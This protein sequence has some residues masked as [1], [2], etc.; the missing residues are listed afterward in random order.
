MQAL[1]LSAAILLIVAIGVGITAVGPWQLPPLASNWGLIDTMI[2]ITLIVTG[3]AFV[4]VNGALAYFAFKYRGRPE[5]RAAFIPDHP[6]LEK[7]LIAITV[8]GIVVLLAPGLF[9]YSSYIRSP[10]EALSVEVLGEQWRWLF[11]YAGPDGEL[12]RAAPEFLSA[13]N[14][15]GLDPT[16]PKGQDDVIALDALRLPKGRP[17]RVQIRAKDVLHSFYVPHF[18]V[19]MDAVPGLVTQLW[20]TPTETGTFPIVC[21]ELCGVG[22]YNMISPVIVMEPE[23]FD[24]WLQAQVAGTPAPTQ[25]EPPKA[26]EEETRPTD[27]AE[28]GKQLA[29]SYGCLACHTTDGSKSVGPTWQGLYG[30]EVDV[31]LPDG[32][33]Q[34]VVADEAYIRESI[35]DPNAKV[36]KGY[37]PIMPP[38][39]QLSEDELNALVEYI[40]SLGGNGGKH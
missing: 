13:A 22:H 32:S 6:K 31:V 16:D 14:P 28:W 5:A 37:P 7:A 18:R 38:Y 30:A 19:K 29:Q 36:H 25:P 1:A 23:E 3:V 34:T 27:P 39:T 4:A 26:E 24:A 20:F 21:A 10:R 8:L 12:G 17:V 33:T 11:R 15:F 35:V 40:K 2:R 9:T